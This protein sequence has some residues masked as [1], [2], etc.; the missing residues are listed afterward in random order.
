MIEEDSFVELAN[1]CVRT[2]H[3]L[4]DV[5]ERRDVD[6]LS[7]PSRTRIEDLGRCVNLAQ[8]SL[9]IITSD[10]R[11]V[12]HIELVVSERA[13]CNRDSWGHDLGPTNEC[14]I[15]LRAEMWEILR[16][17]DVRGF[18]FTIPMVSKLPQSDPGRDGALDVSEP[19]HRVRGPVDPEPS[20]SVSVMVRCC[21]PV[22]AQPPAD[23]IFNLGLVSFIHW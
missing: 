17:F 23:R 3:V 20:S 5:T 18:R 4:R 7:S 9:L 21:S 10:V 15:A 2:C 14:L 16:V 13:N 6:N 1:A 22:S 12:R 19:G 8:R 11:I